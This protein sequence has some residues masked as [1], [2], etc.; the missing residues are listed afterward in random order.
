MFFGCG[1][2]Q[3]PPVSESEGLCEKSGLLRSLCLEY[4]GSPLIARNS[5]ILL[6]FNSPILTHHLNA[7]DMLGRLG[8]SRFGFSGCRANLNFSASNFLLCRRIE[9]QRSGAG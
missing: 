6:P 5:N 2:V 3:Q 1:K 7:G 4:F 9:D 8:M